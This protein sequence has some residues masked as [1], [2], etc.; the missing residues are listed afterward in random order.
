[1]YIEISTSKSKT[2]DDPTSVLLNRPSQIVK[3]VS[4]KEILFSHASAINLKV[5][6]VSM[7]IIC[8]FSLVCHALFFVPRKA[9]KWGLT[10][11]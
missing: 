10:Q 3:N 9:R 11:P 6:V 2:V 8:L 7:V 4:R 1:M 5:S